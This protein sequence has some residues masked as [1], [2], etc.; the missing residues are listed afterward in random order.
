MAIVSRVVYGYAFDCN[1][2]KDNTHE[3]ISCYLNVFAENK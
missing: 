3:F 1:S 2:L